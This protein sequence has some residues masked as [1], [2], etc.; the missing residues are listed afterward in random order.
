MTD[1]LRACVRA[2]MPRA[3][4][5]LSTLVGFR[6]VADARQFPPEECHKAAEWVAQ[7]CR[8]AGL[9]GAARHSG[10]QQGGHRPQAGSGRRADRAALLPLRRAAAA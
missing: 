7:A 1:D 2:L 5:D 4:A 6:S 10:R 8:D 9:G 3:K